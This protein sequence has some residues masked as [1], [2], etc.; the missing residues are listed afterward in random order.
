[1]QPT[2]AAYQP[3]VDWPLFILREGDHLPAS[4]ADIAP[5]FRGG[6]RSARLDPIKLHQL[7]AFGTECEGIVAHDSGMTPK[8]TA[9]NQQ[10]AEAEAVKQFNLNREQRR[11]LVVIER[12]RFLSSH[13]HLKKLDCSDAK[14]R[15]PGRGEAQT[16]SEKCT[17]YEVLH[18][19]STHESS[20]AQLYF[21]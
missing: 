15:C 7:V 14:K 18:S 11:R 1:M 20:K 4:R 5:C 6:R 8:S 16:G 2:W 3:S 19:P 9:D 13:D 12:G 21:V 10:P 17:K